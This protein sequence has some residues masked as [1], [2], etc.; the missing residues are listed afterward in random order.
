MADQDRFRFKIGDDEPDLA[1]H[2]E[3]LKRRVG[4]LGQRVSFLTLLLPC[5]LAIGGYVAYRDLRLR[6]T[7]VQTIEIESFERR[8]TEVDQK[9]SA[10]ATR[11]GEFEAG[12]AA[13]VDGL[14]GSLAALQ[15]ELRKIQ[16]RVD[17]VD[18]G[19]QV[20]A[21]AKVDRKEIAE[22]TARTE[23]ALAAFGKDLQV[24]A[25]DVQALAPFREE[26]GSA[27]A[28][29]GEVGKVSERLQKLENSLGKDLTGLAGYVERTKNDLEK[30]KSDVAGLQARKLDREAMDLETLK[31]KR[32]YQMALDQEVG[33]IDRSLATLQR[34]LDQV[35]KAFGA[36]SS[37]PALPPL[38]GGVKEHPLE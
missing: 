38:T 15:E 30:I 12:V 19:V 16:A 33:R 7:Q 31:T 21:T 14:R 37:A 9:L 3:E 6:A 17:A 8:T 23:A 32:L 29:R 34:R 13:R 36:R 25:K 11:M 20:S 5:L 24:V 26:L 22:L 27:A 35:E 28:L 2:D 4:K 10:L 18:A 1:L